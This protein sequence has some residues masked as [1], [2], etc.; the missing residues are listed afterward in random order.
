MDFFYWG[1]PVY[2]STMD[3]VE[4]QRPTKVYCKPLTGSENGAFF[5]G[6]LKGSGDPLGTLLAKAGVPEPGSVG[7][8]GFSAFHGFMEPMLQA[9]SDRIDY[10]HLADACFSGAGSTTAKPGFVAFAKRAA[11]GAARMTITTNGPWGKDIHYSHA[12]KSYDLTSGAKCIEAVWKAAVGNM[13]Q[14]DAKVPPGVSKPDRIFR[15]GELYWFHYESGLG[16][17]H[18]DHANKLAAPYVQ[19]YGA[20]W[21]GGERGGLVEGKKLVVGS[22]FT[23]LGFA[24]ARMLDRWRSRK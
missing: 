13:S 11:S 22:I 7:F 20:P 4:W 21:M 23:A 24:G 9:A 18:G 16:D 19:L 1:G 5:Y 8:A 12:G 14:A 2:C 3:K 17:P 15:E 10:V 6:S